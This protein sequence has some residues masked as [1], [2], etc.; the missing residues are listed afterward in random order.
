MAATVVRDGRGGRITMTFDGPNLVQRIN[1]LG[2]R[3]TFA[4]DSGRL[5]SVT[6]ARSNQTQFRWEQPSSAQ[7]SIL[8]AIL[9]PSGN[10][11]SYNYDANYNVKAVLDEAAQRTTL[12]WNSAHNRTAVIDPPG[13][14]TTYLWNSHQQFLALIDS[15]RASAPHASTRLAAVDPL[16][17]RATFATT[18]TDWSAGPRMAWADRDAGATMNR[19]RQR[20]TCCQP[21][22]HR[23]RR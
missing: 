3:T 4:W 2:Q 9:R 17:N 10:R 21:R 1:Q 20:P 19:S 13:R 11:I 16:G 5:T 8:K 7:R 6:N 15:R 22:C 12:L 18:A 14:R 23:H